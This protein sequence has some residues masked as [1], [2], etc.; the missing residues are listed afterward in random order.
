MKTNIEVKS[1]EEGNAIKTALEDPTVRAFVTTMGVLLA[2]PSNTVRA[3][4]LKNVSDQLG[5]NDETNNG[6]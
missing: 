1:R 6:K 2:L 3:R 4:V 5:L